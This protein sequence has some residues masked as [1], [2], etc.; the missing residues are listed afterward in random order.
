M[1]H[2]ETKR[3]CGQCVVPC[4]AETGA[5]VNTGNEGGKRKE[6]T[7]LGGV[8]VESEERGEETRT[9][10]D[11]RLVE[12]PRAAVEEAGDL[13]ELL[14]E[15]AERDG[16]ALL[17]D[18][19]DSLGRGRRLEA[20][21]VKERKRGPDWGPRAQRLLDTAA[22]F[23]ERLE[24]TV[25]RGHATVRTPLVG[26]AQVEGWDERLPADAVDDLLALPFRGGDSPDNEVGHHFERKDGVVRLDFVRGVPPQ[27]VQYR[28][29]SAR[30]S[31]GGD[32]RVEAVH[33]PAVEDEEVALGDAE[34][35]LAPG[36][37]PYGAFGS[38]EGERVEERA[39]GGGDGER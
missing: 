10:V 34:G 13:K 32:E 2:E 39:R 5:G 37:R 20:S 19:A 26:P 29:S 31:A 12:L 3:N 22:D 17:L 38:D 25:D 28:E 1:M 16:E 33:E 21:R 24:G 11:V 35:D 7:F 30:V 14:A 23:L 6:V 27:V 9:A 15:L 18:R 4:V 8:E 36:E